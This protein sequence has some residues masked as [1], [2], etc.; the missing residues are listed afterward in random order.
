MGYPV[1]DVVVSGP[2]NL[3]RGK[4]EDDGSGGQIQWVT[5]TGNIDDDGVNIVCT[6]TQVTQ[7]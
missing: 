1:A 2:G 5:Y 4:L 3:R 7:I 6:V